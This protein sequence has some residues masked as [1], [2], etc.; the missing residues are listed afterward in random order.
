M[1]GRGDALSDKGGGA[2]KTGSV[3]HWVTGLGSTTDSA[4]LSLRPNILT[5]R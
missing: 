5:H 2:L 3:G 1:K 4:E